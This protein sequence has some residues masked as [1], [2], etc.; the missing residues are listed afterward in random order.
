MPAIRILLADDH[1][2]MRSGLRLL[3]RLGFS[4]LHVDEWGPS[5]R[6]IAA[7]PSLADERQ[8]PMFFFVSAR[9]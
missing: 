3:L 4:L 9:R 8:R 6:Q 7:Q 2:V 1:V 5:D